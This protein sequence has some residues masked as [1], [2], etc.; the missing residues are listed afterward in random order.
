MPTPRGMVI[1]LCGP[2]GSGKTTVADALAERLDG[3]ILHVHHKPAFLPYPGVDPDRDFTEPYALA[4]RGRLASLAKVAYLYLDWLLAWALRFRPLLNRGGWVIIQRPWSDMIVDQKRYRLEV[5]PKTLR[6]LRRLLPQPDLTIL[7]TAAPSVISRRKGELGADEIEAQNQAWREALDEAAGTL[8]VDVDKEVEAVVDEIMAAIDLRR[9]PAGGHISIQA[10]RWL[11][12][13]E[14][15]RAAVT[16]I[17]IHQP[18]TGRDRLRAAAG[19]AGALLGLT[20]MLPGSNPPPELI[21]RLGPWLE[22]G[23]TFAARRLR[24]G[25]RWFVQIITPEG[26]TGPALKLALGDEARK[27]IDIEREALEAVADELHGSVTTPLLLGASDGVLVMEPVRWRHRPAPLALPLPVVAGLGKLFASTKKAGEATMRGRVHGDLAP[28]NI[29]WDGARW[30]LL[31]WE[32]SR[33]DGKPFHDL[34]HHY[35]QCHALMGHPHAEALV[36]GAQRKGDIGQAVEVYADAAGLDPDLAISA[37]TDYLTKSTSD[38][39]PAGRGYETAR[40]R[41]LRLLEAWRRDM[42]TTT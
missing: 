42:E 20:R 1:A 24:E 25:E 26:N 9:R 5:P 40:R 6:M 36:A 12:P 15:R 16:G 14:P 33:P 4:P 13:R 35:V 31:D 27:A 30:F 39:D 10:G 19:Q 18:L 28:W 34:F 7:L 29:M 17:R 8:F 3:E 38:L 41:R 32:E 37:F 21:T 11:L 22:E 2:D 23:S